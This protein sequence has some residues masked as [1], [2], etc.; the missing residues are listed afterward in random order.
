MTSE[1]CK[2]P[3]MAITTTDFFYEN[4]EK[5]LPVFNLK[6]LEAVDLTGEK[7]HLLNT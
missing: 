7:Q 1:L 6:V 5:E 2:R 3:T 4:S